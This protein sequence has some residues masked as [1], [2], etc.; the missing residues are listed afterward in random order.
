MPD[1]LRTQPTQDRA[2]LRIDEIL[3]AA[4]RLL[5]REGYEKFNTNLLAQES[6]C[7][8]GTVYRYFPEK[9]G[10]I[11]AVYREWLAEAA[12]K[13]DEVLSAPGEWSHPADLAAL[14]FEAFVDGLSDDDHK[15]AVE[16]TKALFMN[17]HVRDADDLH[18]AGLIKAYRDV[19]T[20]TGFS[21]VDPR[22]LDFWA[23]LCFSLMLMVSMAPPAERSFVKRQAGQVIRSTI[24]P[25]AGDKTG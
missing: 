18:K 5:V 14:H 21:D 13:N 17:R 10:V 16:L 20:E 15:L 4:R 8:I 6:G 22:L 1:K 24:N 2:R 12:A 23:E 19:L 3:S 11:V 25:G 9:N 7:N